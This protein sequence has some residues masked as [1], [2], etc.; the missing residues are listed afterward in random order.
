MKKFIIIALSSLPFSSCN[1]QF[2]S[3]EPLPLPPPSLPAPRSLPPPPACKP[4]AWV[5][6]QRGKANFL[7]DPEVKKAFSD[8]DFFSSDSS[9]RRSAL[10]VL[11]ERAAYH[12]HLNPMSSPK[13]VALSSYPA[14]IL[15]PGR[16]RA[17]NWNLNSKAS[18]N[19]YADPEVKKAFSDVDFFSSDSSI[20][21]SALRVLEERAAF[22]ACQQ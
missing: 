17:E 14:G 5:F 20:Y 11:E 12:D 19:F 4:A 22:H 16:L 2:Q 10:R 9:I 13:D 1:L 8:V 6:S 15:A 7:A 3:P 21:R 18:A